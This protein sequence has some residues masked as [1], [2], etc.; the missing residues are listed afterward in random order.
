M[1]EIYVKLIKLGLKTLEEVPIPIRAD[2]E[3]ALAQA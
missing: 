3:N 1:V 2:V